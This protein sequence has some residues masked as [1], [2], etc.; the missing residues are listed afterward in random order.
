M[1]SKKLFPILLILISAAGL[2]SCTTASLSDLIQDRPKNT[3]ANIYTELAQTSGKLFTLD[4]QQSQVRIYVFRSGRF[5]QLGHNHV[6]SAPQFVGFFY[7]PDD[8]VAKAKFDLE[9]RLDELEIDHPQIRANAGS[10]FAGQLSSEAIAGTRRNMLANFQAQRFPLVRIH[11]LQIVGE[12]PK[13]VTNIQIELHG[14]TREL[15]VPLQVEGLPEHLNVSGAFVLRQTDFG[16]QPFSVLGGL[17][18]VEDEVVVEF[19]LT[20][21]NN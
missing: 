11:S 9:F 6:L 19:R 7:L 12:A 1:Y 16:V 15:W 14:Q 21:L 13:F 10:A 4:P 2:F 17:L 3:L 20:G 18:K 5:A 8:G